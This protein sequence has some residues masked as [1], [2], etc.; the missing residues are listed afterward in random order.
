MASE[1]KILVL[2]LGMQ[3]LR[4]A[5]FSSTPHEELRLLRAEKKDLF[6]DPA[7]ETTRPD[8]IKL[9][10]KEIVKEW[11]LGKENLSLVLPAHAVFT[12]V[13]P[14]EVPEGTST[15]MESVINFEAQHNIPFPLEEVIWDHVVIGRIPSGALN[16]IFIA[17]K[18]DILEELCRAITA[19][20][21]QIISI[22]VAPLALYDACRH[23]YAKETSDATTLLLD[24]GSRST[25]LL[26]TAPGSFFS[27]TIPSGGLAIT[28]AIAKDL[29]VEIEEAEK[30]KISRG[31]V[32]LGADFAP[33]E[34]PVE[35]KL[36]DLIR[37]SL[38][39]TQA[40]ISRSLSYYRATLGGSEPRE[41]LL[42]GGMASM[43]YLSEF[44]S[45]KLAKPASFFNPMQGVSVSEKAAAFVDANPNNLGELLGGALLLTHS[46]QTHVRLLPPFLLAKR[47]L[48]S[49]LP[50]LLAAAVI[51]LI[52]LASW[53]GYALN[54]ASVTREETSKLATT[55]EEE[56]LIAS[57]ID[58]LRAALE[59]AN[60]TESQL[61]NLIQLRNAYPAIL[62]DLSAKTPER[63]L[64]MT[65]I[66]P[67]GNTPSKGGALKP[68]ETTIKAISVK[69]LYLDNPRQAA[70]IDDFVTAL[71]SSD[72]FVVEEKEKSK[73]ITQ[74]GS[75]NGEYWAYPFSLILPLRNPITLL[76]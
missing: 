11:K 65:E 70:V 10:L 61:L 58:S 39:R 33:S 51:V 46:P 69:G 18:K 35:A 8:Q 49:R 6:L 43:P 34:D 2:D 1:K 9:A 76:P 67:L 24:I 55:I 15:Q 71:E 23:T 60:Q 75:P 30:L 40:D 25:N 17:I 21:L 72:V 45:E 63:F 5:E 74:R 66:Q 16:V 13:A 48:A 3:S 38:L 27:R 62:A 52:A 12:R 64:W 73:I 59:E 22:S 19:T 26:I 4:L 44:V 7:L 41:V 36:A 32:A 53:Y 20:G 47:A 14:L 54:A 31:S 57:R 37:K 56:T 68:R 42:T 29:H 50:W 28:T